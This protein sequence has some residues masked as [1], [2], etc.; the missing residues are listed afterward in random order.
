MRPLRCQLSPANYTFYYRPSCTANSTIAILLPVARTSANDRNA[1][2]G[3]EAATTAVNASRLKSVTLCCVC[4]TQS[5]VLASSGRHPSRIASLTVTVTPSRWRR[6]DTCAE[7]HSRSR[8]KCHQTIAKPNLCKGTKSHWFL[9]FACPLV[10]HR[11]TDKP[12]N[13]LQNAVATS[14][15]SRV[16]G[17]AKDSPGCKLT[18][19]FAQ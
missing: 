2:Q 14:C 5:G 17:G 7:T 12:N 10:F 3:K 13:G 4:L 6:L 8:L 11:D 9:S 18:L 19:C 16:D 15:R 1:N